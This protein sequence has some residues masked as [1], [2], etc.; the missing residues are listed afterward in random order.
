[1]MGRKQA[2]LLERKVGVDQVPPV[3]GH[4]KVVLAVKDPAFRPIGRLAATGM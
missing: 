1:M 2:G 3:A 4:V